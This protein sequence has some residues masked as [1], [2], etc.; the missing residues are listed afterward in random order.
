[1]G[2]LRHR[3]LI[4]CCDMTAHLHLLAAFCMYSIKF[5]SILELL[6]LHLFTSNMLL[7]CEQVKKFSFVQSITCVRP[8]GH[9]QFSVFLGKK[10]RL[11]ALQRSHLCPQRS[12]IKFCN[13][14]QADSEYA[15]ISHVHMPPHPVSCLP[16]Y[17]GFGL[18]PW[19][20]KE[21]ALVKPYIKHQW[22]FLYCKELQQ[23]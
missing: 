8:C 18:K 22:T 17:Y 23:R 21:A 2:K 14:D 1:M 12:R 6:V 19:V 15:L 11:A 20:L 3:S 7:L 16:Y 4:S 13:V 10:S 9:P 5:T